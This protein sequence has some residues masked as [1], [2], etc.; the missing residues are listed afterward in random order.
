V[1]EAEGWKGVADILLR[2][3]KDCAVAD[4]PA[5]ALELGPETFLSCCMKEATREGSATIVGP[6]HSETD[7]GR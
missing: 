6:T 2:R 1:G 5:R 7:R 4:R 3:S